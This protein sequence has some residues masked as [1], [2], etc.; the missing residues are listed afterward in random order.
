MSSLAGHGSMAERA[1]G[2]DCGNDHA[3]WMALTKPPPTVTYVC[4]R[5]EWVGR[6]GSWFKALHHNRTRFV[7]KHPWSLAS[8]SGRG[9]KADQ[10]LRAFWSGSNLFREVSSGADGC[11]WVSTTTTT[12]TVTKSITITSITFTRI[13]HHQV[14]KYITIIVTI[15]TSCLLLKLEEHRIVWNLIL[16]CIWSI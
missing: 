16:R 4:T 6:G 7:R 2:F 15:T 14:H 11:Q 10:A 3:S 9:W 1:V 13:Y 8:C 5:M 12:T